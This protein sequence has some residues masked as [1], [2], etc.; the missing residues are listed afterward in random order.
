VGQLKDGK[1]LFGLVIIIYGLTLAICSVDLAREIDV[2]DYSHFGFHCTI[3][4]NSI[5]LSDVQSFTF[6]KLNRSSAV[7]PQ[8]EE[9]HLPI[10]S[11]SIFKPPE[12]TAG[13]L[14]L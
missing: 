12:I 13:L 4:L 8:V 10:I 3:D 6:F 11:F 1:K 9:P 5:V 2:K 7:P 14:P